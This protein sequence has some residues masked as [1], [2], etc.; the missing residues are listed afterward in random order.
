MSMQ[1]N[2][3]LTYLMRLNGYQPKH[4]AENPL[5]VVGSHDKKKRERFI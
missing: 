2:G 3:K 5:G 1:D 4:S